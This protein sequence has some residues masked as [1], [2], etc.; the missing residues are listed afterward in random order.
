MHVTID[1][2]PLGFTQNWGGAIIISIKHKTNKQKYDQSMT[3]SGV[4]V[5]ISPAGNFG[6]QS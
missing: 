6:D 4:V 1:V 2:N 5:S 3:R